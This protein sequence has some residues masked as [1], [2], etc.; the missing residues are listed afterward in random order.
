ARRDQTTDRVNQ[1]TRSGRDRRTRSVSRR[2]LVGSRPRE[3]VEG[4][5]GLG[6]L[7]RIFALAAVA[8]ANRGKDD[9]LSEVCDRWTPLRRYFSARAILRRRVANIDRLRTRGCRAAFWILR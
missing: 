5:I 2:S 3:E 9:R 6:P 7:R 1:G 8:A 4:E